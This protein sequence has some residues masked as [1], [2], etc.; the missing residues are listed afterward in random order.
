MPKFLPAVSSI[1]FAAVLTLSPVLLA[2]GGHGQGGGFGGGSRST[3]SMSHV[4]LFPGAPAAGA[5]WGSLGGAVVPPIASSSRGY[6][7]GGGYYHYG[8]RQPT[9]G[10]GYRRYPA[11]YIP[12][13]AAAYPYLG[14]FDSGVPPSGGDAYGPPPQDQPPD[15]MMELDAIHQ[16]LAQLQQR[17]AESPYRAAPEYAGPVLEQ[18]PSKPTDPPL[19]LI[20]RDGTQTEVRD[21]AVVGQVF[22]DLSGHPTRKFPV[23]QLN[24]AATVKANE[25]RGVE[26]PPVAKP[27]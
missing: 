27:Q 19:I 3:G 18:G 23:S 20:F 1:S 6:V 24:L 10:F 12:Y 5:N 14:Y 17:Q 25:D 4:Q 15:L 13:F 22:W 7:S 21:F 9:S 11:G 8:Y 2:Q 26:F 16:E